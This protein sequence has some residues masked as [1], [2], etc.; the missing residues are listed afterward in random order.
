M[1][2]LDV[3]SDVRRDVPRGTDVLRQIDAVSIV[4]QSSVVDVDPVRRRRGEFVPVEPGVGLAITDQVCA[5]RP[6]RRRGTGR[7]AP[8]RRRRCRRRRM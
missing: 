1:H 4:A 6:L 8:R 5:W 3:D 2:G 7:R